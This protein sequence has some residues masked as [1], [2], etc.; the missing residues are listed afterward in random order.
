[1]SGD[2]PPSDRAARRWASRRWRWLAATAAAGVAIVA[3]LPLSDHDR[4]VAPA[5]ALAHRASHSPPDPVGRWRLHLGRSVRGRGI[6]A[7]AVGDLDNPRSVLVVGVIH[8]NEP[9]GLSITRRLA[10]RRPQRERLLIVVP[11]LNPDGVAAGTRQ[12]AH[13]VDLNRNFPWHWRPLGVRGDLQY[14]GQRPLSEPETRAARRLILRR[15][16][17][18]TIWFHQ[19][20]GLVDESGGS[21]AVERR[22]ASLSGLPLRRLPRYPGSAAS[23][24]DHRLPAT[25]AFVVELPPGRPSGH[26]AA[27]YAEAVSDLAM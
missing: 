13:G 1:V 2:V 26:R 6:N 10:S 11:D 12:N 15:R 8:G 14:S 18:I 23:W 4:G 16:P 7:V 25:T 5:G 20:L 27:R 19:P 9:A 22:F 17:A 24:Q 21:L 3:V